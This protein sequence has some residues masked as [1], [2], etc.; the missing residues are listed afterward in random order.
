MTVTIKKKLLAWLLAMACL[1]PLAVAGFSVVYANRVAGIQD[2]RWHK[3]QHENDRRWCATFRAIITR[4]VPP[5][6]PRSREV[7][8]N[9]KNLYAQYGCEDK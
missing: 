3:T 1:S 7:Q 2:A 8:Q 5:D 6:N 9:I 4:E